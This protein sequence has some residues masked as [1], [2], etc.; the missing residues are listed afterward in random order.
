MRKIM[1][2]TLA[3][4]YMLALC[5]CGNDGAPS[6][7]RPKAEQNTAVAQTETVTTESQAM[8][9][10]SGDIEFLSCRFADEVHAADGEYTAMLYQ[11]IEG[12]VYVDLVFSVNN[13]TSDEIS[14][15]DIFG[16]LVYQDTNNT[17]QYCRDNSIST[18]VESD[19]VLPGEHTYVHL[20]TRLPAEA[21]KENITVYY[22]IIIDI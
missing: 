1:A 3:V 22:T 10:V 4:L 16:W 9:Q 2:F 11:Q 6:T 13:Q 14:E 20:F 21:E 15:E 17:L 12:K 5:A 7:Q 19:P 18:T 8:E